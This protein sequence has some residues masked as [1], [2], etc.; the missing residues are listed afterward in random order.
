MKKEKSE[1]KDEIIR[2]YCLKDSANEIKLSAV[3]DVLDEY[4]VAAGRIASYHWLLFNWLAK[5]FKDFEDVKHIQT[6][7]SERY[8]QT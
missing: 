2:T 1:K 7:L 5:P 8:K 4:R 6:K 3:S